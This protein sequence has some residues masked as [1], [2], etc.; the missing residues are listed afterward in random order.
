[1]SVYNRQGNYKQ[2][3]EIYQKSLALYEAA[4]DKVWIARTLNNMGSIYQSQGNDAQGTGSYYQ[5]QSEAGRGSG[6]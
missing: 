2:A 5:K 4:G 6:R 3:L 1:V